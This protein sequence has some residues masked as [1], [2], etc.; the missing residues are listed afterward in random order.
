VPLKSVASITFGAG[1]VSIQRTAQQ[2][3]IAIGADLAPGFVSGQAWKKINA[4]PAVKNL[5]DTVSRLNLGQTKWQT[6]MIQ[7]FV[8]ALL[9]GVLLVFAV[10]VL[11]YRRFLSPFVNM[12][13][14]WLC[15][16]GAALALHIAGQPLSLPVF[17]GLLMLFGIVAKNSILL[18]DFAVEMMNHGM[19]K[20]EAIRE[21]GHKRAQPIVMTTV[22]MVAGMLPIALSITGDSSWRAPMGVTVIGG[23]IFSTLL[24][25]LLVPAYFS[26]AISLES[27]IGRL[28]HRI[29]GADAHEVPRPIAA[30]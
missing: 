2:R 7:N 30:E 29:V 28:F 11:L 25:L 8:V 18:V 20:D 3:R 21:A 1:P 13:S 23:L 9:A 24:T 16:L 6:E 4:L 26:I 5:P 10:L 15:P 14:L 22:A 19:P 27:R 12:G 17:I